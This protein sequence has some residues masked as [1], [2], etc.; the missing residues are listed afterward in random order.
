MKTFKELQEHTI[1][2][3]DMDDTLFSHA[4]RTGVLVH[5]PD[6]K[7]VKRLTSAQ[8]AD[9][10]KQPG[11]KYDW[12]E[13]KSAE[14]FKKS[15]RPIHPMIKKLA[16]TSKRAKVEIL[17]GREDLDN[18]ES[19]SKTLAHH[20]ID[21]D[22]VHVRRVGNMK[23]SRTTAQRKAHYISQ[24]INK[25][26]HKTVHMYDD[27]KENLK[28]FMGLRA[29]HPKVMFHAHHVVINNKGKVQLK[30]HI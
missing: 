9:R 4:D 10:R 28:A 8:L 18:Q 17:T 26:G 12:S 16:Q 15:A 19:F 7:N 20:G 21:T 11:E 6:R 14:H 24:A 25:H 23:D 13:F 5:S 27:S 2:Y 1:H 3:F 30:R 22:K 29:L